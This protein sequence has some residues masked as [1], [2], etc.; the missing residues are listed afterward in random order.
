MSDA[1]LP[2]GRDPDTYGDDLTSP[3]KFGI[4]LPGDKPGSMP[5]PLLTA[6]AASLASEGESNYEWQEEQFEET[7]PGESILSIDPPSLTEYNEFLTPAPKILR[8][9]TVFC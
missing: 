4:Y 9:E 7:A 3:S 5:Q 8:G 2:R 6:R 1:G